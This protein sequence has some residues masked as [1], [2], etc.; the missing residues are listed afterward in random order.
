MDPSLVFKS[1]LF[2]EKSFFGI[3]M[4]KIGIF[5][6]VVKTNFRLLIK[7]KLQTKFSYPLVHKNVY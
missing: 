2:G 1:P 7:I 4:Y 6:L 3:F 5:L